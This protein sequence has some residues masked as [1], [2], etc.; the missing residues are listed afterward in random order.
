[1]VQV[2]PRAATSERQTVPPPT[3]DEGYE[4]PDETQLTVRRRYSIDIPIDPEYLPFLGLMFIGLVLRFWDLGY[5]ALHHDE[6]LHAF[7]S[8]RLYDG[9]GY[10]HDPMMHGPL[11]FELNALVYLLF[12]PSE[13]TARMVPAL[14]GV[15]VIGMPFLLRHELGRAGAIAAS[16]LFVV[17]PAFLYFSRFIR[18]DIYVDAFTLLL[19]IGVFRYLATE[20]RAWFYTACVS[21][22]LLFAT[23]EDFYISGFIPFVFLAGAWFL[24]KGERRML[25]RARIRALG[26]RSW[27]IGGTTFLAINLLLYTTFLTNLQGVCT[28]LVT[29]PLSGCA[30][31][32]GALSY[33]LQQQDFARGGQP[34]FYYFMLLPLYELVPLVLA[35]LAIIMVRPRPLFFWFCTFWAAAALLIYSWAGEKMPWMLPQITLPLI[36][37]AG[38]LLG[39]WSDAGWGRRALTGRGLATGGLVLVAMFGLL[40]WLGLGFA[41]VS[42]PVAQ[43]G[44]TLQRL[45]L[46]V[47]VAAV[48][49]GL[50]FLGSK[51][52]RENLVPGIALGVGAI[53]FAGYIRTSLMVTYDHPDVPVEPLIYVQS[54]HDVPFIASEIERISQQTG[55]GKDMNL[56]LDNG[57]GRR[58]L[59]GRGLATGGLVPG[60]MRRRSTRI[61][62]SP[63][64]RCC[65]RGIRISS[66]SRISSAS[67]PARTSS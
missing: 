30:G 46:A 58:A 13:F 67:T 61:S 17:S 53:F 66:Q 64:T 33:W 8:W 21:A 27:V 48:I 59:T 32:T 7:Y 19:I 41:P 38:R 3:P 45:A 62:T 31:S 39:Q 24:L 28:A 55:K 20:N 9:E 57:W 37:L 56:L 25:F 51:W 43:Q 26:T 5:K 63:T 40:A 6:S 22:A 15:A 1:M 60:A 50:V 4:R 10:I 14:F 52:G 35:V 54:T 11:L 49:G 23:K 16:L 34:W 29:L 36:L 2:G 18:H 42:S 65:W 47:L 44:V 12:G